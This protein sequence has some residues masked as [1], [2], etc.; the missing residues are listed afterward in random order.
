MLVERA[1]CRHRCLVDLDTHVVVGLVRGDRERLHRL[2]QLETHGV[3]EV[4]RAVRLGL[5]RLLHLLVLGHL[6]AVAG[7]AVPV[8]RREGRGIVDARSEG[9]V[10][11][12]PEVGAAGV[13]PGQEA[14]LAE[15]RHG[16]PDQQPDLL[17]G[18][19][20]VAVLVDRRDLALAGMRVELPFD[21]DMGVEALSLDRAHRLRN[22][23]MRMGRGEGRRQGRGGRE[24]NELH[25]FT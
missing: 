6:H 9:R 14:E 24:G 8:G 1:V 17:V 10:L 2:R 4:S 23:Q 5:R 16:V 20:A 7:L 15:L 18:E 21:L 11:R 13:E 19:L 12:R 22:D 3:D 25:G